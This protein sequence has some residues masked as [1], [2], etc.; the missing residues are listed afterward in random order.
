MTEFG[1]TSTA[2]RLVF[3]ALFTEPEGKRGHLVGEM[4]PVDNIEA[5][6]VAA[7]SYLSDKSELTTAELR[8][9]DWAEI[10]DHFLTR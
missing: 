9:A 8:D 6:R 10:Y 5:Y 2:T 4:F 1:S 3:E 7:T